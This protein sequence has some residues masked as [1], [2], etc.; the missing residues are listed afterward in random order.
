MLLFQR[1]N[2]RG[3][4]TAIVCMPSTVR[5]AHDSQSIC[6][7]RHCEPPFFNTCAVMEAW[8]MRMLSLYLFLSLSLSVCLSVSVYLFVCTVYNTARK[9]A[10]CVWVRG[11]G[12]RSHTL[13]L[14]NGPSPWDRQSL[15]CF[16]VTFGAS[17]LP[18][19]KVPTS[20]KPPGIRPALKE[21]L[22]VTI[23]CYLNPL[24]SLSLLAFS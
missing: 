2:A 7:T 1:P 18:Q 4:N 16:F 17:P 22:S 10:V 8:R 12:L 21:I 19:M 20:D 3:K 23:R 13:G 15:G 14:R 6:L 11:C 24:P 9:S 5:A